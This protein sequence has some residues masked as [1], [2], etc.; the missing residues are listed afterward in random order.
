MP[1]LRPVRI[2]ESHVGLWQVGSL[3]SYIQ[4]RHVIVDPF[5]TN[6]GNLLFDMLYLKHIGNFTGFGCIAQSV[7]LHFYDKQGNIVK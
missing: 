7:R 6:L 3:H 2:S 1:C 5:F 4:S